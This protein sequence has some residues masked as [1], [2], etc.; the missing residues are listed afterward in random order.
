M[1]IF[2]KNSKIR[3]RHEVGADKYKYHNLSK[4]KIYTVE[5]II[6]CRNAFSPD[7]EACNKC[8]GDPVVIN[9]VGTKSTLCGNGAPWKNFEI[10]DTDWDE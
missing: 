10:I 3:I 4:G 5:E 8:N 1:T 9:N 6:K 2:K 7:H